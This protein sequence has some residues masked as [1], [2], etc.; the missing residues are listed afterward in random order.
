MKQSK[1]VAT[2]TITKESGDIKS[3]FVYSDE[4]PAQR[5][6]DEME[7]VLRAQKYGLR[8]DETHPNIGHLK[9]EVS[10]RYGTF[11]RRSL[12]ILP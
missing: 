10:N 6:F 2:V 3:Q 8:E 9:L 5:K 12:A 1:V 11:L 4:F 7:R